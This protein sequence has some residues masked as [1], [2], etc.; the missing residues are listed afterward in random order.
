MCIRDR[1]NEHDRLS[2]ELD[3]LAT[4]IVLVVNVVRR[5]V[6]VQCGTIRR[7]SIGAGDT[8][9]HGVDG[10]GN[11]APRDQC[12]VR[13]IVLERA[14]DAGAAEEEA[15]HI[16]HRTAH[17]LRIFFRCEHESERNGITRRDEIELQDRSIIG[18]YAAQRG[19]CL[20]YTSDA[21]DE[22]SSVDLGGRRIIKKKTNSN[23]RGRH[24]TTVKK[25]TT[26]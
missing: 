12:K 1:R 10:D 11:N 6:G 26:P 25:R 17:I 4:G 8:G 14:G 13:C 20:L 15:E 19:N 18:C 21:A 23:I 5:P 24:N 3:H 16:V 2:I 22:R 9:V 7:L